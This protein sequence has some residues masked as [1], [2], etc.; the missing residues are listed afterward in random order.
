MRRRLLPA[1]FLLLPLGCAADDAGDDAGDDAND[2][3]GTTA[4][5]DDGGT[6]AVDDAGT[7]AAD[8]GGT[9]VVDDAGTTAVDDAATTDDA[10]SGGGELCAPAEGDDACITCAKAMCCDAYAA[11]YGDPDCVCAVDCILETGDYEV[12]L[13]ELCNMPDPTPA[14]NIGICYGSTCAADCGFGS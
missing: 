1:V 6:T 2:D 14:M 13:G 10:D 12:C 4:S 9:T 5:A 8:D 11:C 3:G 7:T